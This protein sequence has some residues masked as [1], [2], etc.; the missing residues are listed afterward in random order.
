[1]QALRAYLEKSAITQAA[2]ARLVGVS[3]PTIANLV[4]GKHSASVP[5]LRRLS[6]VTG[7][8]TDDLLA[9]NASSARDHVA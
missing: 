2:F 8:S 9:D 5:L 3:Q 6:L 7:L 1:M 4:N